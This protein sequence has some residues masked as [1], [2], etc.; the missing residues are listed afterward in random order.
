MLINYADETLYKIS[1][2][3]YSIADIA[4]I[5][6]REFTIPIDEFFET[7]R[8]TEY[9]NGYG[10]IAIPKDIVIVMRDDSWFERREYDG[11]EWWTHCYGYSK[12]K[13]R[14]HLKKKNFEYYGYDDPT[15][16]KFCIDY[17]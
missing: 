13:I 1:S 16:E 6:T 12:P 15:L 14:L 11:S 8:A 7:A 2:C 17:A 3:G 4:W 9:N 5:G 10:G